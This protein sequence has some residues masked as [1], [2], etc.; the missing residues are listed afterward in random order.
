MVSYNVKDLFTSLPIP[1]ALLILLELLSSDEALP[2]LR[3]NTA[4]I[5]LTNVEEMWCTI[6]SKRWPIGAF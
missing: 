1:E 3:L 5:L 2:Q 6:I 4:W